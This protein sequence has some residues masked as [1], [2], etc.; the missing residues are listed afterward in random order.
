[1]GFSYWCF[2]L[3]HRILS[4]HSVEYRMLHSQYACTCHFITLFSRILLS[5]RHLTSF[6]VYIKL[7]FCNPWN[8]FKKSYPWSEAFLPH[9]IRL[10]S[11][12][13]LVFG[14][15]SFVLFLVDPQV[16]LRHLFSLLLF[17]HLWRKMGEENLNKIIS[18]HRRCQHQKN[19][20]NF[21]FKNADTQSKTTHHYRTK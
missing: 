3:F 2:H 10:L 7:S 1:M 13:V 18:Q 17:F 16:Q 19:F 20:I 14:I 21:N 5:P 8:Y 12:K 9:A 6:M 11:Q 4:F 15:R